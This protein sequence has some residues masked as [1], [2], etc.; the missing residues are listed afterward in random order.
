MK[1]FFIVA[2]IFIAAAAVLTQ[3]S[4]NHII[5]LQYAQECLKNAAAFASVGFGA[6]VCV[7]ILRKNKPK[8]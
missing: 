2:V 8:H 4:V 5:L 3:H 6:Y 7:E 1:V